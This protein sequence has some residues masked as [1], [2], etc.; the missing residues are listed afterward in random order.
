MKI[1]I[2]MAFSLIAIVCGEDAFKIDSLSIDGME[3]MDATVTAETRLSAKI[4]HNS[5]I[6]RI[7]TAQLSEDIQKKLGLIPNIKSL[8]PVTD[9]SMRN[10][11]LDSL[12][13]N[14][15]FG[16]WRIK[17]AVP[18]SRV[19]VSQDIGAI[20]LCSLDLSD[21]TV[22][23]I[24][25]FKERAD[26]SIFEASVEDTGKLYEYTTVLGAPKKVKIFRIVIPPTE[27]DFVTAL[28]KGETLLVPDSP[29][30][31]LCDACKGSPIRCAK[32]NSTGMVTIERQIR[33]KW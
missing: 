3:Y 18:P 26:G 2:A 28:K 16:A 27:A 30:A 9:I 13:F 7:P 8:S 10:V 22:A 32:C 33:I 5:G 31:S 14:E 25:D 23:L 4:V 17:M 1:V 29:A 15:V 12:K 20:K 6:K 11:P 24:G 19:T 21:D